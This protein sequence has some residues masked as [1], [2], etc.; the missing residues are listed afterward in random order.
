VHVTKP[1]TTELLVADSFQEQRRTSNDSVNTNQVVTEGNSVFT[2][3]QLL[4]KSID[5]APASNIQEFDM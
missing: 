3:K 4:E 1:I 5:G 2:Q